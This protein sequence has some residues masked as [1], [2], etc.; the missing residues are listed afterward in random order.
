MYNRWDT[1]SQSHLA[2]RI[3]LEGHSLIVK[4]ERKKTKVKSSISGHVENP[5]RVAFCC[6]LNLL[7][8]HTPPTLQKGARSPQRVMMSYIPM[9]LGFGIP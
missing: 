5:S 6:C 1:R 2:L 3:I 4:K 7:P 9:C 8:F